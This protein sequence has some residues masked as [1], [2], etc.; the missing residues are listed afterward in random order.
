MPAR[1]S[2]PCPKTESDQVEFFE[3][4]YE[5]FLRAKESAG[6]VRYFYRVGGTTVCLAFAGASLVPHLTPALEHLRVPATDHPP[7]LT[8]CIWDSR[9][10]ATEMVPPP[11]K[12]ED[13]TDRGELWGFDSHRIKTAFHWEESCVNLMDHAARTGIYWVPQAGTL[14]YW[15]RAAPFR[16]LFHW[17]M[18]RNGCQLLHAAAVGTDDGAVLLTGKGGIGKSTTALSCLRSGLR[19]L[20][21]D[22]LVVRLEPEPLAYSLYCTAKLNA[23]SLVHFP[24]FRA[25]VQ[26]SE[27][28]DCEKAVLY[29]YP[30][31]EHQIAT[32]MP[33]RAIFVPQIAQVKETRL[34]PAA[35][36][37]IE[38]ASSFTTMSQ[39]PHVGRHTHD[40][41]RRLSS[42]I[43][44][45]TLETGTDLQKIPPAISDFLAEGSP[46]QPGCPAPAAVGHSGE[47]PLLSVIIPVFNGESFIKDAV[48]SV[49]S[50]N[51][52]ALE[53]I[54]V[55]DGSTDRTEEIVAQLPCD[56]RYFKQGN[57]GPAAA[58]NRGIRDASGEVIAFLDVDDLW[59]DNTLA[60]L[61]DELVRDP[62]LEVIQG[63][64]QLMAKN[65]HTGEYEYIGNPKETFRYSIA[66]A[67]Y[68]KSVFTKV[69]LFD[70]TLI[71]GEDRDWFNR[72]TESAVKMR[73][74]DAVT[75]LVRRHGR[76]MTH[77]KNNI[78]LNG[79]R[80]F[81]KALDRRR[82]MEAKAG[83]VDQNH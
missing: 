64:N 15:A 61:V 57:A 41:I 23:A 55:D 46:G 25:L 36:W 7:D 10:T 22:Y 76:N 44:G 29:L 45:Y 83:D 35:S 42:A 63:Y 67:A 65:P 68:R 40:V 74:I 60:S 62:D 56:V 30:R 26:N 58:R 18:E 77:G 59:P 50:Q 38:R 34:T 72:A 73:R 16:T 9:S 3:R 17:W 79:L 80:V 14:P 11:C 33:L 19:Y 54:V 51:Y 75:L 12:R 13:L 28:L 81:K 53:L 37:E 2:D 20:A 31:F 52:P 78:E 70:T 27:K 32:Q 66:A 82:A 49:L 69:G 71:F 39:L 8:L 43:P 1:N 47:K 5:R 24:D 21:D 48:H 4:C 6:E